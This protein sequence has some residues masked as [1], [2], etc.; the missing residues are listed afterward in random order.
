[1]GKAGVLYSGAA[2]VCLL[3]CS[4]G[5]AVLV[6]DSSGS[7]DFETIQEAVDAAGSRDTLVIR[8]G[9]YE[10]NVLS[11]GKCLTYTGDGQGQT[12]VRGLADAPTF[13]LRDMIESPR[14]SWFYDMTIV[15]SPSSDW[16]VY[17]NLR[18][19]EFHGC[20]LEGLVGSWHS[21]NYGGIHLSDCSATGVRV[22]GY[23]SDSIIEDSMV[24]SVRARGEWFTNPYGWT[25]WAT[26]DVE[27]T[28]SQ[29]DLVVLEGGHLMSDTD[30]IGVVVGDLHARCTGT[31]TTYE[32][33]FVGAEVTLQGCSVAG[34]VSLVEGT[35]Q[36]IGVMTGLAR[37]FESL[38]GGNL[39]I[40]VHDIPEMYQYSQTRIRHATILGDLFCDYDT[41]TTQPYGTQAIRGNIVVGSTYID[42]PFL[43][44]PIVTHNDFVGGYDVVDAGD[45][46]YANFSLPPLF[47]DWTLGDYTLQ[48]C[49]PCVGAAHDGGDI[50]VFGVGCACVT[51]VHEMSWGKVKSLFR[52][53]SN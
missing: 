36:S 33:I 46:V 44:T 38:I 19:A 20:E 11:V 47:C 30:E 53:P 1:M 8:A 9:V 23:G 41:T 32:S 18:N 3:A 7:G 51:V 21:V 5:A 12:V 24:D 13:E 17:W 22:S 42:L 2:L 35:G 39:T 6:V 43:E 27:S 45:M 15:S 10:E 40:D 31:E 49:S 25:A 50:G 52:Q 28:C 48:E 4:A 14:R 37:I 16:A 29:I 26:H 34:D